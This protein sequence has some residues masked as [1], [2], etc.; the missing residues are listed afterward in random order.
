MPNKD[1]KQ[2]PLFELDEASVANSRS[3]AEISSKHDTPFSKYIVY[4]DESGDHSLQSI[5]DNYPLFVL[6]FCNFTMR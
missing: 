6:A 2:L 1:D 5:D 3:K 4:V